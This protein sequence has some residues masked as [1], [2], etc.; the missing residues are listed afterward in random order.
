MVRSL[1][2]S[3]QHRQVTFTATTADYRQILSEHDRAN[4]LLKISVNTN[5]LPE[6]LMG[7]IK[8]WL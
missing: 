5:S 6:F 3:I 4:K 7:L 8:T 1:S 2:G